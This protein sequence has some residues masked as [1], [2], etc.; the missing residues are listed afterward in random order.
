M[1][2]IY[3]FDYLFDADLHQ[4]EMVLNGGETRKLWEI[5]E[6]EARAKIQ[7]YQEEKKLLNQLNNYEPK[8]SI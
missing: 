3:T 4:K 5:D 6:I 2:D 7:D 8:K 1:K